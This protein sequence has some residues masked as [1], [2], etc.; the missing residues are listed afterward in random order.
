MHMSSIQ[1]NLECAAR[2]RRNAASAF[3]TRTAAIHVIRA[4]MHERLMA[5]DVNERLAPFWQLRGLDKRLVGEY[6]CA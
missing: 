2:E 6:A 3:D 5:E 4:E 1:H